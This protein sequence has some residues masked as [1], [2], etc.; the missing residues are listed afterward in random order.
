MLISIFLEFKSTLL[1]PVDI[2]NFK[3][4]NKKV[5]NLKKV[6]FWRLAQFIVKNVSTHISIKKL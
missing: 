4:L 2:F 6:I 3:N 5:L 1:I